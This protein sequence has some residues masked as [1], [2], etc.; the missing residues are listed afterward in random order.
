MSQYKE[1]W[2]WQKFWDCGT[3]GRKDLCM[4]P[5]HSCHI[6]GIWT[7]RRKKVRGMLKS[8]QFE[9]AMK[10]TKGGLFSYGRQVLTVWY[11]CIV[12]LYCKS[13]WVYTVEDFIPA[14]TILLLFYVFQVGKTKSA[15]QSVLMKHWM[16][17]SR[18]I[19]KFFALPL[20]IHYA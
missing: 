19:F 14:F 10:V 8:H 13:Y 18:K 16:G 1:N 17:Y 5:S 11:G 4:V 6:Y 9:V 2:T 3:S 7:S 15:T 12:K 20:K